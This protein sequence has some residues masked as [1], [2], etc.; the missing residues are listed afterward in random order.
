MSEIK[1]SEINVESTSPDPQDRLEIVDMDGDAG[2]P[3]TKFVK[4]ENLG[5]SGIESFDVNTSYESGDLVVRTDTIYM[6]TTSIPG[7]GSS[8]NESNWDELY[9]DRKLQ[10]DI[11]LQGTGLG[12]LSS[13]DTIQTGSLEEVLTQLAVKEISITSQTPSGTINGVPSNTIEVGSVISFTQSVEV[14][15][16][17]LPKHTVDSNGSTV[18]AS[19]AT[20]QSIDVIFGEQGSTTTK[21]VDGTQTDSTS[22]SFSNV[23]IGPS[24]KTYVA[25]IDWPDGEIPTTNLGN[26]D[27]SNQ[28]SA[29]SSSLSSKTI[30]SEYKCFYGSRSSDPAGDNVG[31]IAGYSTTQ[32]SFDTQNTVNFSVNDNKYIYIAISS[33]LNVN[34]QQNVAGTWTDVSNQA[35]TTNPSYSKNDGR[36]SNGYILYVWE[37]DGTFSGDFRIQI[38]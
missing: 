21:Q 36:G 1:I 34:L 7:D 29:G 24:D 3:Q 9:S 19:G 2:D 23:S 18:L 26:D 20:N 5:G 15:F 31:T 4:F 8:F 13:G 30:N 14:D 17:T 12:A 27:P 16:G 22:I 28:I 11:D 32:D 38:S 25:T 35:T 10:N 6:A 33:D 37:A